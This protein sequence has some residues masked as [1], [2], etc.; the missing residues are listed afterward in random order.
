MCP[1]DPG[2]WDKNYAPSQVETVMRGW[3]NECGTVG[4]FMRI[5]DDFAAM[6]WPKIR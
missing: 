2:V 1:T 6:A 5:Y 4:G 3:N